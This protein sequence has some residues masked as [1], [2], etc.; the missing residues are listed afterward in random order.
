MAFSGTTY[1]PVSGAETAAAGQIVQSAVWNNINTDYATALTQLMSQ[2]VAVISHKNILGANGSADIWQRGAGSSS[3]IAVASAIT[4]YTADRWYLTNVASLASVVSAATALSND[5]L[6]S[7]KILR[8]AGN[9][10]TGTQ[11]FGYPLDNDE[12]Q[13]MRGNKVTLSGIIKAGANWSPT[14]GTLTVTLYVGTGA[15]A[16]RGGGF[17][18]ET[19]VLS[20]ATNLSAGGAATAISGTSSAIVPITATQ[21]E[22]QFSWSPTGTAGAD[23]S[24]TFDDMQLECDLSSTTWTPSQFDRLPFSICLRMCQRFY[25]KTFPYGVAPAQTGG[26]SGA[27]AIRNGVA[28]GQIGIFWQYPVVMYATAA[29]TSFNTSAANANWRDT[30]AAADIVSSVDPGTSANE[31]G[32]LISGATATGTANGVNHLLYIHAQAD[33]GL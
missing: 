18:N 26:V 13:R 11:V 12:V 6:L 8:N 15:P 21:G 1:N 22:V 17:T 29:V 2:L 5:S 3:S 4:A 31:K 28:A 7:C 10:A 24:F 19:N 25:V 33:A 23:D 9:T 14:S 20:I 30:T 32:V 16:K 27:L